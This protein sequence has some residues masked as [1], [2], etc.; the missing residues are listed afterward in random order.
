ML[1]GVEGELDE[2]PQEV[3]VAAAIKPTRTTKGFEERRIRSVLIPDH[4]M[5]K[6]WAEGG[7]APS[8]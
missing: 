7:V 1:V 4:R 3:S 8:G 6:R 5:N 2:P